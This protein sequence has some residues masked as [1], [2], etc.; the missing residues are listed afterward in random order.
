[1]LLSSVIDTIPKDNFWL[2]NEI[3]W[4]LVH[5][6]YLVVHRSPESADSATSGPAPVDPL[7][8]R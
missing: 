5:S 7:A 1:M 6:L 4:K 8:Y 3:T 2:I